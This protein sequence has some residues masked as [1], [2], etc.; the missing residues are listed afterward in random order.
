MAAENYNQSSNNEIVLNSVRN[1]EK[2]SKEL[3]K[4]YPYSGEEYMVTDS[5]LK[6]EFRNLPE[7]LMKATPNF[8]KSGIGEEGEDFD[9]DQH[10]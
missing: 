2:Y 6:N 4:L 1:Y 7:T 8:W 9:P 10:V 5:I 3:R